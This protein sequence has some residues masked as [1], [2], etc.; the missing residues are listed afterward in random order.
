[1]IALPITVRDRSQLTHVRH[2]DFV[3]WLLKLFA[4]PDRV[5]SSLHRKPRWRHIGEPLLDSLRGGTEAPPINYFSVLVEGAVM[6]PDVAK[7]DA[8]RDLNLG[9]SAR[10]FS[11]GVLRW[12]LYG[13][14]SLSDPEDLLIP[15]SASSRICSE[16][17]LVMFT[18]FTS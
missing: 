14:Q 8:D 9:L 6:A 13:K 4:D 11:D 3:P 18:R 1:L 12:L 2:D 5:S 17:F 15:F 7:V 10:D 16:V